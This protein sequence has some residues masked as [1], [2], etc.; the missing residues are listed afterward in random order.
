MLNAQEIKKDFPIFETYPKLVYLDNA[1]TT[2]K[3]KQ[4]IQA[5]T[6]YYQ[7]E[8]ANIHR[9]IYDLAALATQKYEE[10]RQKI[11]EY[12]TAPKLGEVIFTK[13]TTESINLVAQSFVLP[14]L[15]EGDNIVISAMEHHANLVVWQQICT[16][17]K[18]N[19]RII[20]ITKTGELI[21]EKLDDLL[22]ER[23]KIVSIIHIS[24]TL[25]TINPIETIITKAH[26]K[27]IPVL[28]DGAQS[29]L[30]HSINIEALDIDFFVFSGHK[31]LGPTGI[32]V[33]YG[34]KQFLK[35]MKPYQFGGDMIRSV[36]F[37]KTTFAP[38]P[39][40]FEAGTPNIAGVIGLGAALDYL[41]RFDKRD[42]KVH[43]QDLKDLAT[44]EL[45]NI[46][47]VRIIGT[48]TE[49]SGI[50]SF[51]LEGVHPHDAATFLNEKNVAV[52]AGHHCTQPLMQFYEISG[53]LRASFTLYNTKNDVE[54]LIQGIKSCL[55]FFR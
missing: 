49:K 54:V 47:K 38:I 53:T 3:P 46:D 5:I 52:R 31:L 29:V 55:S 19:L 20:P 39:H 25:G 50:I 18:A 43:I 11:K 13:G 23:T 44:R 26:K 6:Q 4:V 22:D 28:I 16:Q 30:H 40:K 32:G 15:E 41:A 34:K 1:A 7:A 21:L 45:L 2:Q 51:V 37:E 12:F 27:N 48:A 9:G 24:N 35:E 17:K 33:L 14:N 8:N 10:T 36:S 42:L